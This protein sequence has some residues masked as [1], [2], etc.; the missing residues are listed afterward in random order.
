MI[1]KKLPDVAPRQPVFRDEGVDFV[2][3]NGDKS[4]NL[5]TLTKQDKGWL[6]AA[7]V[8]W[9]QLAAQ[10]DVNKDHR[11]DASE[12][13]AWARG[14][15]AGEPGKSPAASALKSLDKVFGHQAPQKIGAAAAQRAEPTLLSK[16]K[17][18][19]DP[20]IQE[21][22]K[23]IED[24]F[25]K[26]KNGNP[27]AG[28]LNGKTVD[29]IASDVAT[30]GGEYLTPRLIAENA[31]ATVRT[32]SPGG[33][34]A[35][36]ENSASTQWV[37]KGEAKAME[38]LRRDPQFVHAQRTSDSKSP[39]DLTIFTGG[40]GPGIDVRNDEGALKMAQRADQS[41][42]ELAF[43]CHGPVV[44][45]EAVKRGMINLNGRNVTGYPGEAEGPFIKSP[46]GKQINVREGGKP[47]GKVLPQF[48]IRTA[49]GSNY[50]DGGETDPSRR[51]DPF[52]EYS[53]RSGNLVTGKNPNSAGPAMWE[54]VTGFLARK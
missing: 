18:S 40:H 20:D 31:G 28:K 44:L 49:F 24:R 3:K 33:V 53:L 23:G 42:K 51:T 16:L 15:G 29:L 9:K 45:A 13:V 43:I 30:W 11:L 48:D 26:D 8:N 39:A 27:L 38:L 25:G 32:F 35:I 21:Y 14:R 4:V 41:G 19:K 36:D 1:G 52:K 5:E 2:A 6:K 17:A 54:A 10:G 22:V 46:T 47:D 37:S 7:G 50:R 12:A 34:P